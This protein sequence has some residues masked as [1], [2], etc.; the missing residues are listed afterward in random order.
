MQTKEDNMHT[1]ALQTKAQFEK[2]A[3]EFKKKTGYDVEYH[4]GTKNHA[5]L[6]VIT[7][8]D[9]Y[10]YDVDCYRGAIRKLQNYSK[11]RRRIINL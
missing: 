8:H 4:P 1:R 2:V 7:K 11:P 5:T 6:I 9:K 10:A 3:G